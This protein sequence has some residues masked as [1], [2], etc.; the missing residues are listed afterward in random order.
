MKHSWSVTFI[1]VLMFFV[2][3]LVGLFVA[4]VYLPVER[5]VV[6]VDT[7][8]VSTVSEYQLPYGLEPPQNVSP[9]VSVLSIMVSLV[10]A[11]LLMLVL[12]RI[13]AEMFLRLWFLVVVTL[14]IALAL[15][16]FFVR[17]SVASAAGLA[18]L[19]A[20]PLGILK[21][22]QRNLIVHN[23][24]ELLVYPGI[25]SVFIPLLSVWAVVILL[26]LISVYDMW[27]VWRAGFMQ[28]MAK[29]QI[30][31]LK[32]FSGFFVPYMGGRAAGKGRVRRPKGKVKSVKVKVNVAILGGGDVVFP[33]L[34]AGVVLKALG[35]LPALMVSLGATLALSGLFYLSEKGKFYPAMPFISV[36][37]FVGL[38]VAFLVA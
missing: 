23:A 34:L 33:I 5:Q 8:E 10:I 19:V 6:D 13:R 27:A 29:F 28:R 3:Q 20:V 14:G 21:I 30:E 12:M 26:V 16:A 18:L 37:C 1:L 22:F 35:V 24:T 38:A 15:N 7:G 9:G 4:Q 31:K 32:V 17:F 2:A 11:V 25:A 36:G